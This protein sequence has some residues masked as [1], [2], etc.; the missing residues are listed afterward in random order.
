MPRGFSHDHVLLHTVARALAPFASRVRRE[1]KVQGPG[2]TGFADLVAV[3]DGKL[4][5]VEAELTAKRVGRD[6]LK[7]HL[8]GADFLWIV[9]PNT[10]VRQAVQRQLRKVPPENSKDMQISIL[11][12]P[13][14]P[15]QVINCIS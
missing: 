13:H 3:I 12:L 14:V 9:V 4:L 7:A 1:V 11:L 6:V 5:V 15:Q 2:F 8:L 10:K